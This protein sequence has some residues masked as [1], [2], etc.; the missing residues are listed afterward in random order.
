MKG[1]QHLGNILRN[2]IQKTTKSPLV[3]DF[4]VIQ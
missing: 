1:F 2:E 3:L 4:G